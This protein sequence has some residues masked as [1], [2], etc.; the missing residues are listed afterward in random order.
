MTMCQSGWKW[1]MGKMCWKKTKIINLISLRSEINV[2]EIPSF[3]Y[4][5]RKKQ[6]AQ[7]WADSPK[8]PPGMQETPTEGL[9]WDPLQMMGRY[10]Y[11]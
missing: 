1:L 6:T 5:E 2:V 9:C 8:N 7:T 3:P 11:R 4:A 10:R